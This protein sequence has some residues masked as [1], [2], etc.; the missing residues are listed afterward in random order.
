MYDDD[1]DIFI[2]HSGLL[3]GGTQC[4]Y[5]VLFAPRRRQHLAVVGSRGIVYLLYILA[6]VETSVGS[7][8]HKVQSILTYSRYVY[9]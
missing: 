2:K 5:E 3:G 9:H 1:D 8:N 6:T 4:G 7:S